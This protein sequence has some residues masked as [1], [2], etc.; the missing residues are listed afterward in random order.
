MIR[1]KLLGCIC[2]S[3]FGISLSFTRHSR[4]RFSFQTHKK[5]KKHTLYYY[6]NFYCPSLISLVVS[7][8]VKHH[9]YLLTYLLF[10]M[11]KHKHKTSA[12]AGITIKRAKRGSLVERGREKRRGERLSANFIRLLIFWRRKQWRVQPTRGHIPASSERHC[13]WKSGWAGRS[14]FL[15]ILI[16][17][18]NC[19]CCSYNL[20]LPTDYFATWV[21]A[22]YPDWHT[23]GHNKKRISKRR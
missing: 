5:V 19:Y 1:G 20:R 17:C 6:Y 8:D 11:T 4:Q 13:E 21:F 22:K 18:K 10:I 3:S 15:V 23:G 16:Y 2:R 12:F 14:D 9:V 7:V